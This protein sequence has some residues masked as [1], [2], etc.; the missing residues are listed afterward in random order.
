MAIIKSVEFLL[1]I[2]IFNARIFSPI[3]TFRSCL[4]G[5]SDESNLESMAVAM[6]D[7][8]VVVVLMSSAYANDTHCCNMFKYARLTLKK[9]VIIVVVDS[10]QDWKKSNIGIFMSDEVK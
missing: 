5:N 3:F 6:R 2:N 9:P 8:K 4:G 10:D 1:Q 7:A